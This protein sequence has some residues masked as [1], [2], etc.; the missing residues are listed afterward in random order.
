MPHLIRTIQDMYMHTHSATC[1]HCFLFLPYQHCVS[2]LSFSLTSSIINMMNMITTII[3]FLL[4]HVVSVLGKRGRCTKPKSAARRYNSINNVMILIIKLMS[5]MTIRIII[6]FDWLYGS[7][8]VHFADTATIPFPLNRRWC[9]G[10]LFSRK[11]YWRIDYSVAESS[12]GHKNEMVMT[13]TIRKSNFSKVDKCVITTT[14]SFI[15]S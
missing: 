6:E 1:M 10:L 12:S 3:S 11:D 13:H 4:S 9:W 8:T 2:S 7:A 14:Q 5:I 15:H